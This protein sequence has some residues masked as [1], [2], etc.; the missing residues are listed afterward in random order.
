MTS[1]SKAPAAQRVYALLG[2]V[3]CALSA[4]DSVGAELVYERTLPE[5][6]PQL[7][8]PPPVSCDVEPLMERPLL[9][10]PPV[11][12]AACRRLLERGCIDPD[13][14]VMDGGVSDLDAGGEPSFDDVKEVPRDECSLP[15]EYYAPLPDGLPC[16]PTPTLACGDLLVDGTLDGVER[17][18]LAIDA[19]VW[20]GAEVT[21]TSDHPLEVVLD[22][23]WLHDVS[24]TLRG[25]VTL[26]VANSEH[27]RSVRVRVMDQERQGA[28]ELDGV[29]GAEVRLGEMGA[30]LGRVD[31][32]RTELN[33]SQTVA[34]SVRLES[35][36]M[37]R[38]RLEAQELSAIDLRAKDVHFSV[39]DVLLAS[40]D[41]NAAWFSRCDELTLIDGK[42]L[43]A[44]FA[45]CTV[46][47]ARI[48]VTSL[49]RGSFDGDVETDQSAWTGVAL[50]ATGE[51]NVTAWSTNF[52]SVALC[53]GVDDF[54]LGE[55]STLGCA[56]CPD[57][58]LD[59]LDHPWAPVED[60]GPCA[61]PWDITGAMPEGLC[62]I[63][64]PVIPPNYVPVT[65]SFCELPTPPP[66]CARP[67][68]VPSR[69]RGVF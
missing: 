43:N 62:W 61:A 15:P 63:P 39:D 60:A 36:A 65:E 6:I 2:V 57:G 17:S 4:C 3:L 38:G 34:S 42:T 23:A 32:A 5:G 45:A 64:P 33:V 55:G 7:P 24:V 16:G 30:Q 13:A 29:S 20:I 52:A 68:P 9:A 31:M 46:R 26:R 41:L 25:P 50:G 47:P 28:V 48:F 12:F 11:N 14:G 58:V 21:L 35:V 51:T 67:H 27:V 56:S 40:F 59:P 19:P 54:V 37:A 53:P 18:R 8:C 49:I 10:L 69:P 66:E 22:H 44:Q 1:L